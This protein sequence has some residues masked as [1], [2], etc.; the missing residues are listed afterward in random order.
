M[1]K[2]KKT[3]EERGF[4][5]IQELY[6]RAWGKKPIML[7]SLLSEHETWK[8]PIVKIVKEGRVVKLAGLIDAPESLHALRDILGGDPMMVDEDGDAVPMRLRCEAGKGK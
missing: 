3:I 1:E 5:K 8:K 7:T 6:E 2:E 4:E